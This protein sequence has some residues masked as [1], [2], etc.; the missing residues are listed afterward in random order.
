MAKKTLIDGLVVKFKE[1]M[2]DYFAEVC[3]G[4]D[5]KKWNFDILS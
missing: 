3:G 1:A 5:G 2:M 4:W